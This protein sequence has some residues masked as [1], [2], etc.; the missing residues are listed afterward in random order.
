MP[1]ARHPV[2]RDKNK[3]RLGHEKAVTSHD[4]RLITV[5]ASLAVVV[6]LSPSLFLYV[7]LSLNVLFVWFLQECY[8][9]FVN[10]SFFEHEG[11][12]LCEAHYHQSRGSLC[13]A[14]QQPILGR[15]VTAMGAKFHPNHL[16]CHFCLKPLSKGCFKEQ[17]NKPYCHPCFIKLFGWGRRLA[18]SSVSALEKNKT[19]KQKKLYDSCS[20]LCGKE[21]GAGLF[22]GLR[23]FQLL[24]NGMKKKDAAHHQ[25]HFSFM[26]LQLSWQPEVEPQRLSD[27]L[28]MRPN[29][30]FSLYVNFFHILRWFKLNV[31]ILIVAPKL[32]VKQ[33]VKAQ[34][35]FRDRL[36]LLC[37]YPLI[38]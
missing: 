19:T 21:G 20:F 3:L 27:Q 12:P 5:C 17:E 38:Y 10:G 32:E 28:E 14:C 16:V 2:W 29:V 22:S 23:I 25:L 35:N 4:C 36:A 37:K 11:K 30:F 33:N 15:C 7:S 8:T 6:A 26:K 13:Q 34:S 1:S 31:I 18:P 24:G 9:P